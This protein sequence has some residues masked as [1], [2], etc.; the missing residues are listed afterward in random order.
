[1]SSNN[2]TNTKTLGFDVEEKE[3][4]GQM[5]SIRLRTRFIASLG[6]GW[7]LSCALYSMLVSSLV[8]YV[9]QFRDL[10]SRTGNEECY[11][12]SRVFRQ[13]QAGVPR[14]ALA[15][16]HA[17]NPRIAI[18]MYEHIQISSMTRAFTML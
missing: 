5:A 1:M 3:W 6:T 7:S 11:A 10:P 9:G 12:Q 4:S 8:P 16:I 14:S 18:S 15:A 2:K 13:P 17:S